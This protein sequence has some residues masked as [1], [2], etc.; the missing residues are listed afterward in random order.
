MARL[1]TIAQTAQNVAVLILRT[2][3]LWLGSASGRPNG[4]AAVV[5]DTACATHLQR[6]ITQAM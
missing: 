2:V 6:H 5:Q 3:T 1:K 4:V